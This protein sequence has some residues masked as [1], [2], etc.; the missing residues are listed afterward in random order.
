MKT[1]G[2]N[3][4]SSFCFLANLSMVPLAALLGSFETV[5]ESSLPFKSPRTTSRLHIKLI[6]N[7]IQKRLKFEEK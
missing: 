6:Q 5:A 4:M 2:S 7:K 1:M 3:I